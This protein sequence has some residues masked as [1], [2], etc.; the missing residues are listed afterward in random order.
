M[1]SHS[2]PAVTISIEKGVQIRLD[3]H[4]LLPD[5]ND[6]QQALRQHTHAR[7]HTHTHTY[8]HTHTCT[9]TH[10][11]TRTHAH[12]YIHTHAHTYTHAHMH[13]Q[14][15][16][17]T[18]RHICTHTC[19]HI[20]THTHSHM[21][22][23]T[24]THKKVGPVT[25]AGWG[26]S[27]THHAKR[28]TSLSIRLSELC[29]SLCVRAKRPLE[30]DRVSGGVHQPVLCNRATTYTKSCITGLGA[31]T[32][33]WKVCTRAAERHTD[34]DPAAN[35]MK[36]AILRKPHLKGNQQILLVN[37]H[38]SPTCMWACGS[39]GLRGYTVHQP[40]THIP[41]EQPSLHGLHDSIL[42]PPP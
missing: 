38:F 32:T 10:M 21:H 33:L 4:D 18:G 39:S 1:V 2:Y 37:A 23:H 42:P 7:A 11:H 40:Q 30:T 8:T 12:T 20:Y 14:I 22:T 31:M 25:V 15:Q 26:S 5:I 36:L 17:H 29:Q 19:T 27:T 6:P 34:R 9:H 16:T 13:T 41:V 24:H 3:S 28:G 35:L